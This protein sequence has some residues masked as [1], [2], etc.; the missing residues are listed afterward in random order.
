MGA[1]ELA[2]ERVIELEDRALEFK[3]VVV[4][5][6]EDAMIWSGRS[7]PSSSAD[8]CVSS[9]IQYRPNHGLACPQRKDPIKNKS[10]DG[11]NRKD[12]GQLDVPR[13]PDVGTRL[14]GREGIETNE[15]RRCHGNIRDNLPV[16]WNPYHR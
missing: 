9:V 6:L 2:D 14:A 10:Y 5:I 8:G 13:R 15:T 4:A 12:F 7:G 11:Q 3:V 16:D 1:V